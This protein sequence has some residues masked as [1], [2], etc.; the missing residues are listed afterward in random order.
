M[1][2]H[3]SRM[4]AAYRGSGDIV[5]QSVAIVAWGRLQTQRDAHNNAANSLSS[6]RE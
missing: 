3:P 5:E 1:R 2:A 4:I 6:G